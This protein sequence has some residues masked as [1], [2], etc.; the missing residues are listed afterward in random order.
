MYVEIILKVS[1]N[2]ICSSH[3]NGSIYLVDLEEI[4]NC[5]KFKRVLFLKPFFICITKNEKVNQFSFILLNKISN[6]FRNKV[7]TDPNMVPNQISCQTTKLYILAYCINSIHLGKYC[8]VY[9]RYL[10]E[11]YNV[12]NLSSIEK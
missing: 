8:L 9:R 12:V 7:Q 11:D 10:G 1:Y 6:G 2:S 4:K 3:I 5:I